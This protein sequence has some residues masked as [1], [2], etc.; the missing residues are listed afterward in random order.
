ML[1]S[2]RE[3][4]GKKTFCDEMNINRCNLYQ[5]GKDHSHDIFQN[6][7]SVPSSKEP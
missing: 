4:R 1:I 2:S 7:M 5:L 3:L 6:G